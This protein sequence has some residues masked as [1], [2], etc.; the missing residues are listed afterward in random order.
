MKILEICP[1]EPP[2]SGWVM[3][4]KL[5]RRVVRERGGV[6][7]VLDIG[8]SRKL[9]RPDCI[10]VIDARDFLTKLIH[11]AKQR[12]I[13]H[14]HVNGEYFRGLTLALAA[15]VIGRVFRNRCVVTF[16][17]GTTQPFLAGWKM[18]ALD[19]LFRVIFFL[20]HAVVC[21]SESVR[22]LLS[23]YAS[24]VK[25]FPIQAFSVQY[26][27]Y[28]QAELEPGLGHWT[29]V[30]SP[31]LSTYLCFRD[32]FFLDVVIDALRRLVKSWPDL[33]LVIVGTGEGR[34]HFEQAIQ[35]LGLTQHVFIAGDMGHDAF[36]TLLSKTRVHLRTPITDGVSATVL[37]ALSLRVP[38]V[39]SENGIRPQSVITYRADDPAHLADRLEWVLRHHAQIAEAITTS[40]VPDTATMEVDLLAGHIPVKATAKPEAC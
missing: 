11:F 10:S 33:G 2:A 14:C 35:A 1:Y 20:A 26:L 40:S 38:V 6:C 24:A 5:L 37:E 17:A 29:N 28:H 36:M 39:A 3:R 9:V 19:P 34:A 23:R 31:V 21:N 7:E 25:I 22:Q 16:H 15:C 32:G 27:Q 18:Y 8:P 4:L 30:R 12:Y 13:F